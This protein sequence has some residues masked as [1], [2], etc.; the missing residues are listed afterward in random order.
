[1][2]NRMLNTYSKGRRPKLMA[3]VLL[4]G[5]MVS[6]SL[7]AEARPR[8]RGRA[9]S[10]S[11]GRA[12]STLLD[13]QDDLRRAAR[14]RCSSAAQRASQRLHG[15]LERQIQ[16]AERR[17]EADGGRRFRRRARRLRQVQ[18]ELWSADRYR[19]R[20]SL[21]VKRRLV[22]ELLSLYEDNPRADDRG[23]RRGRR[24]RRRERTWSFSNRTRSYRS[25]A[26]VRIGF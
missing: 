21:R 20:R 18:N 2:L 16:G 15:W 24:N 22:R 23:F 3:L 7:P 19:E 5:L 6:A 10:R 12:I 1:M 26:S 9:P 17:G 11:N 4:G 14:R 13:I 8:G 25:S